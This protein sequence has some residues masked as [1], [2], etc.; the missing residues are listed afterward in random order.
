MTTRRM[1]HGTAVK[2]ERDLELLRAMA[3]AGHR[4][5]GM[6]ALGQWTFEDAPPEDAIVALTHHDA[7]D[8]DYLEIFDAAGWNHVWGVGELQVFKAAPGTP[9]VYSD[10]ETVRGD[11]TAQ[12]RR[13][14]RW[15]AIRLLVL[16][17]AALALGLRRA[18]Q[19]V[20]A[21]VLVVVAIP[22]VY[23]GIPW[24]DT[25]RRLGRRGPRP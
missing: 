24:L 11:L 25:G 12:R 5:T 15:A 4:L 10:E 7:P 13:Y 1:G 20:T 8:A 16:A 3:A 22:V 14:G 9:P 17:V 23:S 19:V 2:P 6:K 21:A 18:P